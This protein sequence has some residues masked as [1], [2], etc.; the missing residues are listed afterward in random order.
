MPTRIEIKSI[1][2][3]RHPVVRDMRIPVE[4]L[5]RKLAFRQAR[6]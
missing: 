3:A 5:L 4:I 1:R 6:G 2:D